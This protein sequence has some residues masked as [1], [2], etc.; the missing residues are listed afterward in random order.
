MSNQPPIEVPQGAIRLNTDSQKLEFFAQDRW[1]EFATDSPTLDGGSRGFIL[2]G[3]YSSPGPGTH[4][5]IQFITIPTAGDSTDF[6]DLTHTTRDGGACASR[7]RGLYRFGTGPGDT[8]DNVDFF[9]MSSAG[10]AADF[11][12]MTYNNRGNE[13]L[14]NQT[15]GIFT[16]G[17]NDG[18][19]RTYYNTIEFVT[20]ASTGNGVDFGDRVAGGNSRT[21]TG[22]SPTRGVMTGSQTS[23]NKQ[24]DFITIATTGN[25]QDFGD[26]TNVG[27]NSAGACSSTRMVLGANMS[28]LRPMDF[29]TIAT[30]GNSISFGD[31]LVNRS[32]FASMSDC[33]RGIF[34]GGDGS[35]AQFKEIDY[36]NIATQGDAVDFGDLPY[37]NQQTTGCSNAHGGL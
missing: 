28:P 17:D 1:Y 11:G 32:S 33:V 37:D 9:T 14:A 31:M 5:Q 25:S 36:F 35:P 30:T 24:I 16:G 34:A 26:L 13:G 12:D 8:N 22:S 10:N 21:G 18:S 20:I 19:P 27:S 23:P 29:L 3:S 6:G 2:G 4:N 15:R 7:T